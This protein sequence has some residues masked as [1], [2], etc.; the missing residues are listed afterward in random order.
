MSDFYVY[1]YYEDGVPYYIGKG[2]GDRINGQHS[3][4]MPERNQRIV[5]HQDLTE[6]KAFEI[7]HY[8]I[9]FYGREC[10]GGIL[11]NK[12]TGPSNKPAGYKQ[13]EEHKLKRSLA[14]KGKKRGP[15]SEEAKL[16][17]SLAKRGKK[18]PPRSPEH[19]AKIAERMRSSP[20]HMEMM[21]LKR[22]AVQGQS[23]AR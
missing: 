9:K 3:V 19:R 6:Q 12:R 18:L 14:Q 20:D 15:M 23:W 13:T 7:E 8:L 2:K 4:K 1:A 21:R 16:K 5:L 11:L 17:M 22:H 10:D